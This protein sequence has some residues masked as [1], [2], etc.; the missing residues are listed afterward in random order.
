MVCVYDV[1]F[2]PVSPSKT[3]TAGVPAALVIQ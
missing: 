2:V 3:L 1:W